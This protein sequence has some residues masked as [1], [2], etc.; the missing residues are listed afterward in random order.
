MQKIFDNLIVQSDGTVSKPSLHDAILTGCKFEDKHLKLF[1]FQHSQKQ[2]SLD[3][4]HVGNF[5]MSSPEDFLVF[6]FSVFDF[7]NVSDEYFYFPQ[8]LEAL[9][10]KNNIAYL[11]KKYNRNLRLFYFEGG[12]GGNISFI[13]SDASYC[14][15]H[16][17]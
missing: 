1:F 14:S 2:I 17:S 11:K 13:G 3:F 10:I 5:N 7:H 15:V 6:R 4:R 8:A 16:D 12:I 9:N